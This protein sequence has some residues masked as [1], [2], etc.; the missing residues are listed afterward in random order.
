MYQGRG[1]G[2]SQKVW[3]NRLER[4]GG[5]LGKVLLIESLVTRA[6]KRRRCTDE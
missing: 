6:G 3:R 5:M 2:A 1:D 4:E